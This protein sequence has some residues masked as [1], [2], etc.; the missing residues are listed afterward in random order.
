MSA[1][2]TM[3]EA[4]NADRVLF[5]LCWMLFFMTKTV[6]N[7]IDTF[8]FLIAKEQAGM[9]PRWPDARCSK[10]KQEES[11]IVKEEECEEVLML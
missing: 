7:G 10:S 2:R 1:G 3:S 6:I 8:T 11:W 9:L 5:Q 4:F